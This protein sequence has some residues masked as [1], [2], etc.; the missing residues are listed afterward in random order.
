MFC[1][2]AE[3]EACLKVLRE[4]LASYQVHASFYGT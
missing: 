4:W 2:Y 1:S 3:L